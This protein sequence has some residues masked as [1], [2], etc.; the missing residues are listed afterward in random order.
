MNAQ[1]PPLFAIKLIER[2]SNFSIAGNDSTADEL[3]PLSKVNLFVGENNSGKS[4]FLRGLSM[5]KLTIRPTIQQLNEANA[6]IN[7]IKQQV[8][9]IT[10]RGRN[11]GS[12]VFEM[13]HKLSDILW[14]K[15]EESYLKPLK[16][17]LPHLAGMRKAGSWI[18]VKG[19]FNDFIKNKL[20]TL[21]GIQTEKL[22]SLQLPDKFLFKKIYI[23][24]LRGLK[25]LGQSRYEDIY[26]ARTTE[27]YFKVAKPEI[28]TGLG[29]YHDFK[30]AL[31]G[32]TKQ[33]RWAQ[34]FERFISKAFFQSRDFTIIPAEESQTLEVKIG[35]ETQRPIFELGDGIQS[36]IILTYPMF[37]Y[38]KEGVLVFFE[39]PETYLHP[40]YQRLFL[41]TLT[42]ERFPLQQYFIATHSNHFLDLT[43]DT[44]SIS[45]F[46]FRRQVKATQDQDQEQDPEFVI[47]NVSNDNTHTLELLGVRNSSVFLSNCT[48]WVEGITDRRYVAHFLKLYIKS[49]TTDGYAFKEDLHFSFVEYSGSNITHWSFLDDAKDAIIAERLCGRLSLISDNDEVEEKSKRHQRFQKLKEK[50]GDRFHLLPCRE[51]E[52]ILTPPVIS[53]VIKA[54]EGS[55]PQLKPFCEADYVKK[56][57]GDFIENELLQNSKHKKYS[58]DGP[59]YKKV[60]FC[61][62]ALKHMKELNDL[63]EPARELA[64]KLYEFI[65][66][67]N[68]HLF[69]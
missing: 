66:N 4:R 20:C 48:I 50:L 38:A 42:G 11:D 21:A 58:D 1:S 29:F 18:D 14:I 69:K 63:S 6:I 64:K 26:Q 56:Q 27:D 37:K 36:I 55:E 65:K 35:Q 57:L 61:A 2:F 39:E 17:Y 45:V 5:D 49:L 32:S 28:I 62:E 60:E 31:L 68:S 23:P 24:T 47:E 3:R 40:A 33:R 44:E 16:E 53:A 15:E 25:P 19:D 67:N 34:D 54:Y 8:N 10:S 41:D 52:N 7:E 30:R 12:H 43:A 9:D 46:T 22:A 13:S 59:I 51:I